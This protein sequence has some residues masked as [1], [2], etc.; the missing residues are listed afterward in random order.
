MSGGTSDV[1]SVYLSWGEVAHFAD[2]HRI[3]ERHAVDGQGG[4]VEPH[5]LFVRAGA[6]V[7]R[8]VLLR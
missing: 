3:A 7:L 8:T 5:P 4:R 2:Q 1:P 6:I